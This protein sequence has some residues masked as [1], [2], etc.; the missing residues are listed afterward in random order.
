MIKTIGGHRVCATLAAQ[1]DEGTNRHLGTNAQFLAKSAHKCL[2]LMLLPE[3][4]ATPTALAVPPDHLPAPAWIVHQDWLTDPSVSPGTRNTGLDQARVSW[5][6][7]LGCE[8]KWGLL[9]GEQWPSES[10][11]EPS[12]EVLTRLAEPYQ[13]T[14]ADLLTDCSNFRPYDDTYRASWSD[15][16]MPNETRRS[17]LRKLSAGLPWRPQI[18]SS[19]RCHRNR[20]PRLSRAPPRR[21][22]PCRTG[23]SSR[24]LSIPR[25]A[26]AGSARAT[27]I[28]TAQRSPIRSRCAKAPTGI[29]TSGSKG[30]RRGSGSTAATRGAT[31]SAN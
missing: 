20:M 10:G 9:G 24:P 25:S 11:Y 7:W 6:V 31:S 27:S 26:S 3:I 14:V 23:R 15:E 13:C 18:R 2:V 5:S 29:G 4:P 22:P 21:H 30:K 8:D 16:I 17:V 28:S 19:Q 1:P 12:L